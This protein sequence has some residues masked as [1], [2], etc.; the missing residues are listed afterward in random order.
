MRAS[1]AATRS[2]ADLGNVRILAYSCVRLENARKQFILALQM[3]NE[4]GDLAFWNEA[5]FVAFGDFRLIISNELFECV[6]EFF[7]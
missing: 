1:G 6:A 5:D 7:A 3:I 4:S 2:C